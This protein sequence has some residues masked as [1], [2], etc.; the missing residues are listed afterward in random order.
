MNFPLFHPQ[1]I[2]EAVSSLKQVFSLFF[3]HNGFLGHR[4]ERSIMQFIIK[5]GTEFAHLCW[6]WSYPPLQWSLVTV[7]HGLWVSVAG[8]PQNLASPEISVH[9]TSAFWSFTWAPLKIDLVLF[10]KSIRPVLKNH[11]YCIGHWFKLSVELGN[12]VLLDVY[13][14]FCHQ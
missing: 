6:L 11:L 2:V 5:S 9:F 14:W 1:P 7:L 12:K 4:S 10:W 3:S 13:C 8:E